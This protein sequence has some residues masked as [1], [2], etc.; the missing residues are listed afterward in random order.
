MRERQR[1]QRQ[2]E[3]LLLLRGN[4][5]LDE[6]LDLVQQPMKAPTRKEWEKMR[7]RPDDMRP[8]KKQEGVIH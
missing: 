1:L 4:L 5:S 7:L 8:A 2:K 6:L 3:E